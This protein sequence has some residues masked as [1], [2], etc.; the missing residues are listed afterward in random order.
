MDNTTSILDIWLNGIRNGNQECVI[1][2]NRQ[3][4]LEPNQVPGRN[5]GAFPDHVVEDAA[6]HVPKVVTEGRNRDPDRD[7]ADPDH[8]RANPDHDRIARIHDHIVRGLEIALDRATAGNLQVDPFQGGEQEQGQDRTLRQSARTTNLADQSQVLE[9]VALNP[10]ENR[11]LKVALSL[12][13][14][15]VT[16]GTGAVIDRLPSK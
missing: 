6:I 7:R 8:D 9:H 4:N 1:V 10:D 13:T 14:R 5:L 11:D 3:V 16:G 12:V 2:E 15:I